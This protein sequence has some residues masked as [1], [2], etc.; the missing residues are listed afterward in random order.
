MKKYIIVWVMISFMLSGCVTVQ[1]LKGYELN[2]HPEWP[3]SIKQAIMNGKLLIGMTRDQVLASW[4]TNYKVNKTIDKDGAHEEW[5]Y[6][7]YSKN[8]THLY[9]ENDVLTTIQN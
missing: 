6:R 7:Y 3:D 4:G 2:H 8:A 1:T 9:F 5:I